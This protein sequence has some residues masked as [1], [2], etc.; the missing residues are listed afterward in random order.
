[1]DVEQESKSSVIISSD[2]AGDYL[3]VAGGEVYTGSIAAN[4]SLTIKLKQDLVEGERVVATVTDAAN[5]EGK[6]EFIADATPPSIEVTQTSDKTVLLTSTEAGTYEVIIGDKTYTG[7]ITSG[8]TVTIN[9]VDIA[10]GTPELIATVADKFGNTGSKSLTLDL[11][12]P[13]VEVYQKDATTLFVRS[14]ED[15][16][17]TVTINGTEYSVD[18]IANTDVEFPIN[19]PLEGGDRI[20]A[21]A[22][23]QFGNESEFNNTV[24]VT[25]AADNTL[26]GLIGLDVAGLIDLK[27]QAFAT[28]DADNNLQKVTL[29][30]NKLLGLT[31]VEFDY[32][33]QIADEFGL[34]ISTNENG[35]LLGL[36]LVDLADAFIIIE[37]KDGGLLDNQKVLEFLATVELKGS[38]LLGGLLGSLLNLNLLESIVIESQDSF[39]FT[40]SADIGSLLG[41]DLLDE[42]FS[43]PLAVEGDKRLNKSDSLDYADSEESV[44]LYGHEGNDTLTGGSANDIIRGGN[45]TDT[46]DGG[47]GNDYLDGGNGA[48]TIKGG[49]GSDLIIGGEGNDTITGGTGTDLVLFE[50]LNAQDATGGNGTDTWTDFEVGHP[51]T[52]PEADILD[53]SAL[54]G[55]EVNA[56]NIDQYLSV[57]QDANGQ[58]TLKIDRDGQDDAFEAT[59]LVHLGVQSPDL[60]LQQL[61]DNHQILF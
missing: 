37:E 18:A 5:N 22:Q 21:I 4:E 33:Q 9:L 8:E 12:A 10:E 58:V 14:D 42:L 15:A 35:G 31:A 53:V 29:Y 24:P 44:R 20:D 57:E 47:A 34:K 52:N 13:K 43:T 59:A 25:S 27:Q 51:E 17:V 46:I 56:E 32:S 26:L 36:G 16:T 11:Q 50:L 23:D 38:G 41:A 40:N 48:D 3:I 49:A 60:S 55:D 30:Q 54:L 39:G 19:A 1:M 2:E 61:L 6:N 45:G 28:A 7:P